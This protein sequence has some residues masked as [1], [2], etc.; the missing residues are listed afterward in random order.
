[1]VGVVQTYGNDFGRGDRG[2]GAHAFQLGCL[3]FK[4]GGSK[5]IPNQ[6]KDL[7]VDNLPKK[8]LVAFLKSANGCHKRATGVPNPRDWSQ[9]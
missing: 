6:A 7:A 5:N 8:D 2:E 4:R 1:M 9:G 3:L